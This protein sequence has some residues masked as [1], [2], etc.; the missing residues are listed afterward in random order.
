MVADRNFLLADAHPNSPLLSAA[1]YV[2]E[3]RA[4]YIDAGTQRV[5]HDIH[6]RNR[7]KSSGKETMM[8]LD[9]LFSEEPEH[10]GTVLFDRPEHKAV[11]R[12]LFGEAAEQFVVQEQGR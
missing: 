4:R 5:R 1:N 7:Y 12:G 11:L 2:Y 6:Q 8:T 3:E 10:Q 9:R